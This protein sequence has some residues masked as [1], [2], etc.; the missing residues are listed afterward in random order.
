LAELGA[1]ILDPVRLAPPHLELGDDIIAGEVMHVDRFG[2]VTTTIG[3]LEWSGDDLLLEPV[4]CAVRPDGCEAGLDHRDAG[5]HLLRTFKAARAAVLAGGREIVGVRRT[6]AAA[7]A[8]EV[9]ALVG[10][11]GHL[12]IAVREGSAAQRLGLGLGDPVQV[13]L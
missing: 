3:R 10:S 5:P 12:E 8:G 1:P 2:N 11:I 4:A 9:L 6:Y 13:R 7:R